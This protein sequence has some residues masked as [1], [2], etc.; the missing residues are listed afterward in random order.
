MTETKFYGGGSKAERIGADT[1]DFKLSTRPVTKVNRTYPLNT[2]GGPIDTILMIHGLGA[3]NDQY[4]M[5]AEDWARRGYLV[6]RPD[7]LDSY[8]LEGNAAKLK[9]EQRMI[10]TVEMAD[11]AAE[12]VP[13]GFTLGAFGLAGHSDGAR[14]VLG[15]LGLQLGGREKPRYQTL[16]ASCGLLLSPPG[17]DGTMVPEPF[18]Q[19]VAPIFVVTGDADNGM[20]NNIPQPGTWRTQAAQCN[21]TSYLS[22]YEGGDHGHGFP[23][24]PTSQTQRTDEQQQ[25]V[26]LDQYAA[27]FDWYLRGLDAAGKWITTG[28]WREFGAP[29]EFTIKLSA[30]IPVEVS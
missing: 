19:L 17:V 16:A 8:H 30:Q 12:L 26:E 14:S 23:F 2:A 29:L 9:W 7:M 18:G 11:R 10:E 20:A 3:S 15:A 6:L 28:M 27:F 5:L 1:V 13:V 24:N 22:F 21:V 25:A 4:P